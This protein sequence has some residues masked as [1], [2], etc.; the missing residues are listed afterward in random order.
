[1]SK[2]KESKAKESKESKSKKPKS[3]DPN[4]D[5]SKGLSI[6]LLISC[7]ATKSIST[8]DLL[9]GSRLK[10][11]VSMKEL[12]DEWTT[13]LEGREAIITPRE[14]FRGMSFHTLTK[15]QDY[16][17]EHNMFV[18]STANG[19]VPLTQKMV[20]YDFTTTSGVFGNVRDKVTKEVFDT[21]TWWRMINTRLYNRPH[22]IAELLE[23]SKFRL[24]IVS[25][26]PKTF[27]GLVDDLLSVDP[28]NL[29]KLRIIMTGAG[30][31]AALAKFSSSIL[32]FDSRLNKVMVGNRNDAATRASWLLIKLLSEQDPTLELSIAEHQ[33]MINKTLDTFGLKVAQGRSPSK[34]ANIRTILESNP[35]LL[36]LT[37][38]QAYTEV[39]KHHHGVNNLTKFRSV[40]V[41]LQDQNNATIGSTPIANEA[42][43]ETLEVAAQ[44]LSYIDSLLDQMNT[45][46]ITDAEEQET[47]S[48]LKIF[49]HT[50]RDH[51]PG[52]R[53]TAKT[54]SL[55]AEEFCSTTDTEI[56]VQLATA[57][58]LTHVLKCYQE[59]LGIQLVD[60]TDNMYQL[61]TNLDS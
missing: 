4:P 48:I 31:N 10:G 37:P 22:P 36:E 25:V 29:Q 50:L 15:I 35:H 39:R 51:R 34:G 52:G 54:V 44:A 26:T 17:P 57:N 6:A 27:K 9:R 12:L 8:R 21:S 19:L 60:G 30:D 41:L 46:T 56:P 40:W 33:D 61:S 45:K 3:R 2:S 20:P 13:L 5:T 55:W 7:G 58:R 23:S 11:N 14:F 47:I 49:L 43:G 53:F 28:K 16:M 24:V 42:Y 18:V 1:M 38:G 59:Y 32:N